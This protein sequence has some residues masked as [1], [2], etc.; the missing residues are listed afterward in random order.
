[1]DSPQVIRIGIVGAGHNTRLKHI[2]LLQQL[3]NVEIVSVCNASR[4]SS[5]RVAQDFD[6]ARIYN[7]W[8]KLVEADD[9]DAILI[10]T[11]PYLHR[12]ITL[13]A[14]AADKHVLCE[15]RMAADARQARE[16]LDAARAKP[17]LVTQ[18]VP[19][20]VTLEFD[21]TIKKLIRDGFLGR[22]LVIELR[23]ESKFIDPAEQ[24][25][26]RHNYAL[27]GYNTMS[28]G[29]WYEAVARWAGTAC[30][31]T[32][33]TRTF[34]GERIN[35]RG[36]RCEI[37][38][39][40]HVDVIA[41]MVCGAQMHM[42]IS[43]VTGLWDGPRAYLFGSEG[44]LCLAGDTLLGGRKTDKRLTKIQIDPAL[45]GRWRVEAEFIN[46]IRGKE[47]VKLTTFE[48]GVKYMEFT[49]AVIRSAQTGQSIALE[50]T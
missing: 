9:T 11:W 12:D 39:P 21:E 35:E 31:V 32:A 36:D 6:I 48:D 28:L 50:K 19:S 38:V 40:D 10:G 33:M 13:A 3:P 4:Q 24:M 44:T 43:A 29:I 30:R 23:A 5:E 17:H 1:M 49:E 7:D 16:M 20:P 8:R 27:S 15:A 37:K 42:Q 41:E 25:H 26:W 18:V 22:L 34:V 14:L 46:A 2:P 45:R 47:K